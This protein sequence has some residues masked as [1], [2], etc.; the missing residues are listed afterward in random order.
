MVGNSDFDCTMVEQQ[1][2]LNSKLIIADVFV[3]SKVVH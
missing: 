3:L 2:M 1:S